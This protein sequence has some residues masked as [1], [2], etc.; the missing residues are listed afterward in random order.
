MNWRDDCFELNKTI[1]PNLLQ[2]TQIRIVDVLR[3]VVTEVMGIRTKTDAAINS[4]NSGGPLV[5]SKGEVV[6][7]N[8]RKE[9]FAGITENYQIISAEGM[10]FAIPIND[11]KPIFEQIISTGTVVRPGIGVRVVT[12]T[13]EI[14]AEWDLPKGVFVSSVT[15]GG[16]ASRAGVRPNDVITQCD[17]IDVLTGDDLT[18]QIRSHNLGDNVSLT[19]YRNGETLTLDVEVVNLNVVEPVEALPEETQQPQWPW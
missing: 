3:I 5:N 8:A 16:A 10:G 15:E 2:M 9:V 13:D 7:I 6:G 12:I 19:I 14:S 17:G 4:G 11:A 1:Q 18:A